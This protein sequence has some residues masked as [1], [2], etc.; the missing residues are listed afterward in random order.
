MFKRNCRDHADQN[1]VLRSEKDYHEYQMKGRDYL[2]SWLI[3]LG[4]G[5]VVSWA[6]FSNVFF[7]LIC[8]VICALIAP[9]F[10]RNYMRDR[11]I[12]TLRDQFRD[13]MD[14]LCASYS[15]GKNTTDAF[16]ASE[17]DMISIHGEEADIVQ[18]IRIITGGM[19]NNVNIEA[20]LG[21]L[22]ARSGLED[23]QSFADIF[24]VC[25]KQGGDLK[26]IVTDTRD[27][28]SDKIEIEMEIDTMLAGN[29]NELN[30]MLVMPVIVVLMLNGLGAG[31]V[32][33][34]TLVNIIL[35]VF[36]VGLFGLAYFIGRK[37]TDIKI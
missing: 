13:L 4:L 15:A 27:I 8:G 28:I 24:E 2:I 12:N 16:K 25:N 37:F 5:I 7:T 11:M 31:T 35:K 36:C 20:L 17:K 23:I 29:K 6:F 30:I 34:N 14:S 3:G 22:A 21:D 18:E 19:R 10:Y 1:G 32:N 33:A 9:R 26:R